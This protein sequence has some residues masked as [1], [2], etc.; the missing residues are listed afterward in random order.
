IWQ[1]VANLAGRAGD[2]VMLARYPDASDYARDEIAEKEIGWVQAVVLGVR[3]IRGEMNI[4]PS[5]L[6][7]VLFRD[8][9][10]EDMEYAGR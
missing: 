9:S 6:I 5:K 1:G 2:S 7:P 3:Q 8:A 4:K 10:A